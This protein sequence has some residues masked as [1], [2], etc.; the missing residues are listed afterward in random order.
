MDNQIEVT[1]WTLGAFLRALIKHQLKAQDL[2]LPH[3]KFA[4]SKAPSKTIGISPFKA[5][6]NI[7]PLG[8]LDLVLRPLD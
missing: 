4:Y 8:P 5:V 2:L 7:D 3:A 6:Y 1:S